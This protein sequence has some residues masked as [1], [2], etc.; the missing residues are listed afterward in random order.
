MSLVSLHDVSIAFG[1]H[2]LL[3]GANLVIGSNERIG[4]LGRN[5]EGKSTLL[6]LI[7]GR[8]QPDEGEIRHAPGVA[9]TLL[10]QAPDLTGDMSVYDVVAGGLGEIGRDL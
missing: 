7:A 10:D 6:A 4:L 9:V 2:K 3:E 8:L 5:G 1:A